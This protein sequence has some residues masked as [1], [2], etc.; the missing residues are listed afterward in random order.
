MFLVVTLPLTS[1]NSTNTIFDIYI[2]IINVYIYMHHPSNICMHESL[3]P[4]TFS[5]QGPFLGTDLRVA[6]LGLRKLH[7]FTTGRLRIW[8]PSGVSRQQATSV[9]GE[10]LAFCMLLPSVFCKR[11]G[12]GTLPIFV[13]NDFG[14]LLGF[15]W[16]GWSFFQFVD[17]FLV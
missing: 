5:V 6:T 12:K 17:D 7:G 15:K 10:R 3:P 8:E 11:G 4:L 13:L 9:T 2:F 14:S 1:F 16:Q